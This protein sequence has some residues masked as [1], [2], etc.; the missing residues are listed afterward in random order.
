MEF[1]GMSNDSKK[2]VGMSKR[3]KERCKDV[4]PEYRKMQ[5]CQ[6]GTWK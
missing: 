1:A 6:S 3:N 2:H 4:K 5:T